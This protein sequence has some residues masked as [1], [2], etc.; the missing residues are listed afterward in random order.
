MHYHKMHSGSLHGYKMEEVVFTHEI[1]FPV[2]GF[3]YLKRSHLFRKKLKLHNVSM[4][5]K[6]TAT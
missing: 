4:K 5:F 2:R 1:M 6:T 3:E